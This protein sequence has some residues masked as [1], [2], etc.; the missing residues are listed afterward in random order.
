MKKAL[1]Q[2]VQQAG[3]LPELASLLSC[4]KQFVHAS[5]N[6][7]WLPLEKAK[8]VSDLYGIAL[9]DLVRS[10]IADAM[11]LAAQN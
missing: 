3:G 5:V 4:S 8:I 10:D 1:E 7:G 6:R 11:R 9:V 2:A